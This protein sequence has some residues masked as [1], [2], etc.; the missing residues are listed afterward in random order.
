MGPDLNQS[1]KKKPIEYFN[2]WQ[3]QNKITLFCLVSILVLSALF[4]VGCIVLPNLSATQFIAF[5]VL[6]PTL[7][8]FG[9]ATCHSSSLE[10]AKAVREHQRLLLRLSETEDSQITLDRFFSISSDLIVLFKHTK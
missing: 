4:V 2:F 1:E 3:V 5:I 10:S 9:I 8:C 6:I 7:A